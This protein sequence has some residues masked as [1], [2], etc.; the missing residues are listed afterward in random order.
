MHIS[1]PVKKKIF[2]R[3]PAGDDDVIDAE[4][5]DDSSMD[6]SH[7]E[8]TDKNIH[9]FQLK[10]NETTLSMSNHQKASS[11]NLMIPGTAS[12]RNSSVLLSP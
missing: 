6:E 8:T 12:Q 2:V 1:P 3:D 11:Q 5:L 7:I 4:N 9:N 10:L